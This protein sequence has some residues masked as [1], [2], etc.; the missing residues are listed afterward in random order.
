M[1]GIGGHH[2]ATSGKDE[3]LTPPEII[4]ALGAFDLDPCAPIARPWDT[5][6]NHYTQV[7]NGLNK[8]WAGRVFCNPPYGAKTGAWLARCADHGNA[9]ALVFARTET[10]MFFDHV[11][12]QATALLFMQGRLHFHHLDGR[13]ALGNSGG[14]TVLVAYGLRNAASLL[15]SDIEGRF[16]WLR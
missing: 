16:V 15:N 2:S 5:A 9:I 1:S 4:R 13:R 12:N 6:T 7:D 3:W 11:W 10:K 14:P 8:P